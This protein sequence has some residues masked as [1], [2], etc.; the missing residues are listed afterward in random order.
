MSNDRCYSTSLV[1]QAPCPVGTGSGCC[2]LT[3]LGARTPLLRSDLLALLRWGGCSAPPQTIIYHLNIARLS[4][5]ALL[6][7]PDN[8]QPGFSPQLW[9]VSSR[10]CPLLGTRL[11]SSPS[12]LVCAGHAWIS[13]SVILF[14]STLLSFLLRRCFRG[15]LPPILFFYS[16]YSRLALSM[17]SA[18]RSQRDQTYHCKSACPQ[19]PIHVHF[20]HWPILTALQT[21]WP[22][23]PA[24]NANRE[25][26]PR[27]GATGLASDNHLHAHDHGHHPSKARRILS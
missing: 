9:A 20:M 21:Q 6:L 13:T 22:S 1:C 2:P 18:P 15:I 16:S 27:R 17:Y 8:I 23:G 25:Q 5:I 12:H 11:P 7:R 14:F 26:T 24:T 19:G 3:G 10:L 4:R